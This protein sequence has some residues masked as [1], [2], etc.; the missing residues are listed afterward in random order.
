MSKQLALMGVPPKQIMHSVAAMGDLLVAIEG[1]NASE[2][3]ATTLARTLGKTIMSGKAPARQLQK[4]GIFLPKDWSKQ[5]TTYQSR[6]DDII[7]RLKFASGSN[8]REALT[9]L[10]RI[11]RFRNELQK[12]REEIGN[13]L[14][15]L[16]AKLADKW[17]NALPTVKVM[18]IKLIDKVSTALTGVIGKIN[19]TVIAYNTMQLLLAKQPVMIAPDY[20]TNQQK[21]NEFFIGLS[22]GLEM[23]GSAWAS[24]KALMVIRVRRQLYITVTHC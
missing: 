2:E 22:A 9:P 13:E 14:I 12:T 19:E 8:I 20:A 17:R 1:V 7:K 11:Q 3:E 6:L 10:G 23:I 21:T 24:L 18:T 15:P 16:Q 4:L 5:F